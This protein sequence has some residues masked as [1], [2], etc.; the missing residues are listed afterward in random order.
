VNRQSRDEHL[1][2]FLF[3]AGGNGMIEAPLYARVVG[4]GMATLSISSLV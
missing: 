2:I 3:R 4:G 1:D